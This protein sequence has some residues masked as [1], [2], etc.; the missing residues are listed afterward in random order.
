M[1]PVPIDQ[2][3]MPPPPFP[4]QCWH[5]DLTRARQ[6]L[7]ELGDRSGLRRNDK[8]YLFYMPNPD[9]LHYTR[10]QASIDRQDPRPAELVFRCYDADGARS[11]QLEVK[12]ARVTVA[13]EFRL[14]LN[15]QPL[16]AS[17]I[18]RLHAPGGRDARVHSLKLDPY[19]QFVV[20]LT[21]KMLN[22]GENRLGVT[23][24]QGDAG[25]RGKI[26]LVELEL[27]L[28]YA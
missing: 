24:H 26:D 13:D 10:E 28:Q 19:S 7:C 2:P 23:L 21:P 12:T 20:T 5:A 9:M 6:A 8:H 1:L 18:R 17:R 4:A 3:A 16:D 14:T 25:V 27:R 22:R 15:G 11:V